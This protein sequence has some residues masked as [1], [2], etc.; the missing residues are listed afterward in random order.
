MGEIGACVWG[1]LACVEDKSPLALL[2]E[3]FLCMAVL[4][5]MT[6][7]AS[8]P[9]L[10]ELQQIALSSGQTVKET[11]P[12]E[13]AQ[14]VSSPIARERKRGVPFPHEPQP[15]WRFCLFP[16][17]AVTATTN[18]KAQ[19]HT[20]FLSDRP[21]VRSPTWLYWTKTTK[22][23]GWFP[24]F[25]GIWK[26]YCLCSQQPDLGGHLCSLAC[27]LFLCIQNQQCS[28]ILI[29]IHHHILLFGTKPLASFLDEICRAQLSKP[30]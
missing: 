23:L 6:E 9:A 19:S 5:T 11:S 10:T 13:I 12:A 20:N 24:S 22:W 7:S 4:L 27:G 29:P 8:S 17:A 2:G 25:S 26:E 18:S 21:G 14:L 16:T 1:K 3:V 15:P 30:R 28:R